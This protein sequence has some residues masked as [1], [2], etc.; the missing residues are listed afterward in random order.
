MRR[1]TTI[2][3]LAGAAAIGTVVAA[4][5]L[6]RDAGPSYGAWAPGV[7]A[8][9]AATERPFANA[10]PAPRSLLAAVRDLARATGGDPDK[11]IE[12]LRML[13]GPVGASQASIYAFK[14]DGQA[15]CLIVWKRSSTCPTAAES[16]TPGVLYMVS[17]GYPGW[18]TANRVEVP[19]ALVGVVADDVLD[20]TLVEGG[21]E[22]RLAIEENAFF[23]E[24]TTA[25]D[26]PGW[27]TLKVEY[28][29]G[30]IATA[31]VPLG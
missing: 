17:G 23:T 16:N 15:T 22:R 29:S 28:A 27:A 5:A 18:A 9:V 26:S 4:S 8:P 14:P 30:R 24:L 7:A 21:V 2:A 3:T 11:A 20:V 12:T 13:R 10:V 6:G 19:S 1:R 25:T 31:R